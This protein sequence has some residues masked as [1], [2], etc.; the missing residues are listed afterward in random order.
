MK[1]RP[2]ARPA[3]LEIPALVAKRSSGG[4]SWRG[5][6]AYGTQKEGASLL[7]N[8]F[9]GA[10]P[11]ERSREVARLLAGV[12][13]RR[14]C[15]HWSISLDPRLGRL[16]DDEW[17]RAAEVFLERMGYDGCPHILTRHSDT[18]VDHAHL[19]VLR[20]NA[21]GRTVSDSND[22]KR[23]HAAVTAAAEVLGLKPL[24]PRPDAA[25]LPAPTD[26]PVAANKRAVRRGTKVQNHGSIAR[27]FDYIVSKSADADELVTAA[28]EAGLEL[29]IK[30]NAGGVYGLNVRAV[31]TEEWSKASALRSDKSLSWTKVVARLAENLEL[32]KRAQAQAAQVAKAAA[33][34]A[35]Q[36]VADRIAKQPDHQVHQP[37]RAH[38]PGA[39]AHAKEAAMTNAMTNDTLEFLNAPPLPRPPDVP[40]DDSVLAAPA[41]PVGQ[42][43]DDVPL[44]DVSS[45]KA[46]AAVGAATLDRIERERVAANAA[47]EEELQSATKTQLKRLREAL[48]GELR[49]HDAEAVE[50][51]LARF[52]RLVL[53]LLTLNQ[54]VL[55]STASERRVH[56]ARHSL[57]LVDAEI[58]RRADVEVR[59]P[60]VSL[61]IVRAHDPRRPPLDRDEVA[62]VAREQDA[63]RE[64]NRK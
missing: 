8:T 61:Q 10:T 15:D 62:Q 21:A 40:L 30:R 27:V 39:S 22:F 46:N 56:V 53:R 38:L 19:L 57:K 5:A 18:K 14:V 34:R 60:A 24:P 31:G 9:E 12:R 11:K 7:L 36:R 47:V 6:D 32:R 1:L 42:Q 51:M 43:L 45:S 54:I 64:R 28:A 37:A 2:P 20:R 3:L 16:T 41:A 50:Q 13:L 26:S 52:T 25:R 49:A 4:T 59:P 17:R 35:G 44:V 29:D 63:E 33:D 55:P 23:S 48:A 58:Q